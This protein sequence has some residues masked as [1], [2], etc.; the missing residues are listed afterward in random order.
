[1]EKKN[2]DKHDDGQSQLA[3]NPPAAPAAAAG[4]YTGKRN[5]AGKE[6]GHGIMELEDGSRYEGGWEAGERSGNTHATS[7]ISAYVP[8]KQMH[9]CCSAATFGCNFAILSTIF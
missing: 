1:M 2:D 8:S 7:Q 4:I 5:S 6:Q 3:A 9:T